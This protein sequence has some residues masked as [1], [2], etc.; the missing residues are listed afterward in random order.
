MK[1]FLRKV[2]KSLLPYQ[3]R[4]KIYK[5]FHRNE[6]RELRNV[7][8]PSLKGDF[9]LKP[10]DENKC[11]F[12]HITKTA[13]TSVAKSLFN[14]LPYHY[15]CIEYQVIFGKKDYNKYY[16]F[17]FVRNPWDRLYSAFRYLKAGGW[18]DEDK[19]WGDTNLSIY[20]DFNDFVLNWLSPDNIKKHIHFRPQYQF[21]CNSK[22]ELIIDYIAYFET[23]AEDFSYIAKKLNIDASLGKHNTNPGDNYKNIYNK[24]AIDKVNSVYQKDISLFGYNF[25]GVHSRLNLNK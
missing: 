18:N 16:K 2:Y 3:Y 1:A 22:D 14:Y 10:Y 17:A 15:T 5:L 8:Y 9:S 12:V 23:I 19:K 25:D 4:M 24:K 7:V 13:G 11:I 6:Y 20:K 21:V